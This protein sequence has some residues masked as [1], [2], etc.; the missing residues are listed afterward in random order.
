MH[1]MSTVQKDV[2]HNHG[3]HQQVTLDTMLSMRGMTSHQ[4]GYILVCE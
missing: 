2:T 3:L 1:N 4:Q